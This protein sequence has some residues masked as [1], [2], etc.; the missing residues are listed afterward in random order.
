MTAEYAPDI[1]RIAGALDFFTILSPPLC[2]ER[3]YGLDPKT[4]TASIA[5]VKAFLSLSL[6]C[7]RRSL[8]HSQRTSVPR[9]SINPAFA[10][11]HGMRN[12]AR[13]Y[14][15]LCHGHS[16]FLSRING[17]NFLDCGCGGP[18]DRACSSFQHLSKLVMWVLGLFLYPERPRI[19]PI[20]LHPVRKLEF[21]HGLGFSQRQS[22][23]QLPYCL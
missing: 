11:W 1:D 8:Q 22:I 13:P 18:S 6:L 14:D 7:F 20:V 9:A 5:S 10:E 19:I 17:S 4:T 23:T 2:S 12:C 21:G 3:P 16:M 15:T